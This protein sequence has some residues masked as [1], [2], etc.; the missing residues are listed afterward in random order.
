MRTVVPVPRGGHLPL[1]AARLF[2]LCVS[3]EVF[4]TPTRRYHGRM[5]IHPSSFACATSKHKGV[6]THAGSGPLRVRR[7]LSP[8]LGDPI[9]LARLLVHLVIDRASLFTDHRISG[10]PIRAKYKH[11]R[12]IWDHTCDNSPTDFISSS[13]K[14]WSSMHGVHTS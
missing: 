2:L 1:R 11:F 3:L 7:L 9:L 14:W 12:T 8:S 5:L 4:A 10:R 6:C 13:L